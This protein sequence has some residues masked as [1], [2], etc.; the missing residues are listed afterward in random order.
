MNT[1]DVIPKGVFTRILF[2]TLGALKGL[3][4]KMNT[5]NVI[6]QVQFLRKLFGTL[7]ALKG[8]PSKMD[9]F[10]MLLQVACLRKT[11]QTF[12][13]LDWYSTLS[14][15]WMN[16]QCVCKVSNRAKLF[17]HNSHLN[18]FK[19]R[20]SSS[21]WRFKWHNRENFLEHSRHSKDLWEEWNWCL[22]RVRPFLSRKSSSQLSHLKGLGILGWK[23]SMWLFKVFWQRKVLSQ[24]VHLTLS[25]TISAVFWLQCL[26][27]SSPVTS[28]GLGFSCEFSMWSWVSALSLEMY[29]HA[30]QRWAG[31]TSYKAGHMLN[32]S[33]H[34][35]VKLTRTSMPASWIHGSR[36]TLLSV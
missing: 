14:L 33:L 25:W 27:C 6:P 17:S 34:S 36:D 7:W 21:M 8:L 4:G 19:A 31:F 20:W 2:G 5:L 35:S 13:A 9:S 18:G 3:E 15:W 10:Y 16:L 29:P 28:L 30:L 26:V 11:L 12:W 1:T 23:Q 32:D 24:N 22:C